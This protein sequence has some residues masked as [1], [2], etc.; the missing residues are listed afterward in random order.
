LTLQ[1]VA[2][3]TTK[4]VAA[5]EWIDDVIRIRRLPDPATLTS[6]ALGGA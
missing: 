5:A 6:V 3:R 1:T 4:M 2:S